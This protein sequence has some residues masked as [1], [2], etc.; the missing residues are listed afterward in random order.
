MQASTQETKQ[1]NYQELV[2]QVEKEKRLY[3]KVHKESLSWLD[4]HRVTRFE[5]KVRNTGGIYR[6][7]PNHLL[8]A[9][10][11]THT[12]GEIFFILRRNIRLSGQTLIGLRDWKLLGS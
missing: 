1:R 11:N 10:L 4:L 6:E 12:R 8:R 2:K 5:K 3:G 7:V 9:S